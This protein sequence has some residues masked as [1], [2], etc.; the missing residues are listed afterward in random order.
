MSK[1]GYKRILRGLTV[2]EPKSTRSFRFSPECQ[3][4]GRPIPIAE[5]GP[6]P[7]GALDSSLAAPDPPLSVPT[8]SLAATISPPCENLPAEENYSNYDDSRNDTEDFPFSEN[9]NDYF[10]QDPFCNF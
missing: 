6:S 1:P 4:N 5:T 2:H 8:P 9:D 7:F 3:C 10:F